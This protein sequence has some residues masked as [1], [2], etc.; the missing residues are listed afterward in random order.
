MSKNSRF[1]DVLR[2]LRHIA[3]ENRPVTSEVLAKTV[4]TNAVVIRCMMVALRD[5]GYVRSEK[6]HDGGWILACEF[7]T[8]TLRNIY[9]AL[10]SPALFALSNRPDAPDYLIGQTV[11]TQFD[12][13]LLEAERLVIS[14]LGEV[15]L[16][17]INAEVQAHCREHSKVINLENIHA[18]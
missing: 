17:A 16:A 7:S 9:L 1:S 5:H 11:N 6:G 18:R 3:H 10:C 8:V 4:K 15:T 13:T 12:Q 14:R 2:V